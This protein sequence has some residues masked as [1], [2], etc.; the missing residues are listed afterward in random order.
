MKLGFELGSRAPLAVRTEQVGSVSTTAPWNVLF[1]SDLHLLPRREHLVEELVRAVARSAPDC[2]LLGGDL[3]D[4]RAGAPTLQRCVA[5][6]VRHAPVFA[7]A[8]NHDRRAGVARVRAAVTAGGGH[9]LAGAVQLSR[10]GRRTL[11]LHGESPPCGSS[12]EHLR[13]LV[14]HHPAAI[15]RVPRGAFDLVFAGHLHGG[16]CVLWRRGGREF[17]GA[18]FAR[19]TGPRFEVAGTVLLVSRGVADTLPVRFRCPREVIACRLG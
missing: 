15:E 13:V 1:A 10:P 9:W 16:Q 14:A 17:P 3:V 18:L 2:V 5:A 4:G 8:G 6:L 7:I 19:W 11:E 12:P